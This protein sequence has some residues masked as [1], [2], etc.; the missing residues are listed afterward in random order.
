MIH[1]F[2][3]MEITEFNTEQNYDKLNVNGQDASGAGVAATSTLTLGTVNNI[4]WGSDS[5]VGN[6][7]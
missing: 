2:P 7:G 6:S 1:N 5:S 4:V 3:Q